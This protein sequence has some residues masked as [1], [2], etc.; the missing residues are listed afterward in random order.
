MT[1]LRARVLADTES[2]RNME[3]RKEPDPCQEKRRTQKWSHSNHDQGG[4]RKRLKASQLEASPEPE[5]PSTFQVDTDTFP[6]DTDIPQGDADIRQP[7]V[8]TQSSRV[9]EKARD[10]ME[11]RW[12][13]HRDND[14]N[15]Q[16][17]DQDNEDNEDQDDEDNEDQDDDDDE[18]GK[19][20]DDENENEDELSL[21]HPGIPGL[22]TWDLLGKDFEWEAAAIGLSSSC[23]SPI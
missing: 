8:V 14:D 2:W 6:M 11:Q 4:S 16:D 22:S 23:E 7:H 17:Q 5:I 9:V 3:Q 12:G 20:E 15:D 18:D 19:D 1:T 13:A 10:A 21:S